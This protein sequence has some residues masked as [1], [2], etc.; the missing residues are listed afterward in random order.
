MCRCAERRAAIL[1]A[2][3]AALKGD[4]SKIRPAAAFVVRSSAE[5]LAAAYRR[6]VGAVKRGR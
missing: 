4:R 5:D 3:A 6:A 1:S 2:G